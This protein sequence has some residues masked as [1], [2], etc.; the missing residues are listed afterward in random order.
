[1]DSLVFGPGDV[2]DLRRDEPP[3]RGDDFQDFNQNWRLNDSS[4]KNLGLEW[5]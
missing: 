2:H 5:I 4:K 3:T 1:M